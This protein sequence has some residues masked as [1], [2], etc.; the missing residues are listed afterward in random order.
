MLYIIF[1]RQIR[2]TYIKMTIKRF[3]IITPFD[4]HTIYLQI[5]FEKHSLLRSLDREGL[6]NHDIANLVSD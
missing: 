1:K 2:E 5:T 4:F 6:L 3:Q